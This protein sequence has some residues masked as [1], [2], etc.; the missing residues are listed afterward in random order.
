MPIEHSTNSHFEGGKGLPGL[1]TPFPR[2]HPLTGPSLRTV[3]VITPELLRLVESGA[4]DALATS[5]ATAES[6]GLKP[7]TL[8]I[9]RT[10]GEGPPFLKL[11]ARKNA[12][13]RYLLS[14]VVAWLK[15]N[16]FQSTSGYG[17]HAATT[18]PSIPTPWEK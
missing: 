2:S 16:R 9:K 18:G 6:L 10:R 15:Q 3:D 1:T 12:P 17:P 7:N 11:G 13:V 8:E 4:V 5:A 14:D